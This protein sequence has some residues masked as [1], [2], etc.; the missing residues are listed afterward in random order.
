MMKLL[1]SVVVVAFL[2]II[3]PAG[4]SA[5]IALGCFARVY[6]KAHLAKHPD[7]IVTAVNA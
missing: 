3:V 4:A 5:D 6:D 7:Q 1:T 2:A